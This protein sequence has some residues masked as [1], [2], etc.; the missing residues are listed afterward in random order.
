MTEPLPRQSQDSPAFASRKFMP[1]SNRRFR[2]TII[3][4]IGII[5]I[6]RMIRVRRLTRTIRTI[7]I[8]RLIRIRPKPMETYPTLA[9]AGK[10]GAPS[11]A[12]LAGAEQGQARGRQPSWQQ[13]LVLLFFF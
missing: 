3:R 4:I 2:L 9:V 6:I 1:D 11:A 13:F 10:R 8:I 5:R 12:P 7:R